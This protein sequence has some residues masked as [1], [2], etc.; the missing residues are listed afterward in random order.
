GP[1]RESDAL[2]FGDPLPVFTK[3]LYSKASNNTELLVSHLRRSQNSL[4]TL[5]LSFVTAPGRRFSILPD[6]GTPVS[7]DTFDLSFTALT[8]YIVQFN[9]GAWDWSVL[10]MA[11]MPL[12]RHLTVYWYIFENVALTGTVPFMP[13][14]LSL[15]VSLDH[16]RHFKKVAS[17]LQSA[18][19]NIERLCLDQ[20]HPSVCGN[21]SEWLAPLIPGVQDHVE[22]KWPKLVVLRLCEL[23][24]PAWDDLKSVAACRPAFKQVSVDSSCWESS[25]GGEQ[26]LNA[27]K[28]H[29]E[30]LVTD[31]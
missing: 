7:P 1:I 11:H 28:K 16:G 4:K 5:K 21:D 29:F 25:K 22:A 9:A 14:L 31:D 19:P 23:G 10:H 26:D 27:L 15:Q 20:T 30:V 2:A 3:L 12:L 13:Q 24:I 8:D 18:T 17:A 6:G